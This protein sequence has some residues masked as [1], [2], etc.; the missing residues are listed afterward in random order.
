MSV[1][2]K[3]A[4]A[5]AEAVDIPTGDAD[6]LELPPAVE[7]LARALSRCCSRRPG[8]LISARE[9]EREAGLD[10]HGDARREAWLAVRDYYSTNAQVVFADGG[11]R[12]SW[13][14]PGGGPGGQDLCRVTFLHV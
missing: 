3:I 9:V 2:S 5:R 11:V 12:S 10:L 1:L 6:P 4:A 7:S 14:L 13:V 8:E